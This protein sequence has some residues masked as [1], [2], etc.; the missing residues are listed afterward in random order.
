MVER[1]ALRARSDAA[2]C[3][4]TSDRMRLLL[5]LIACGCSGTIGGT[6]RT[7]TL[8][9]RVVDVETCAS[10]AGCTGIEGM[11]VSLAADPDG[12][13]SAPTSDNGTFVLSGVRTG[14]RQDLVV[15]P[16]EGQAH[17]P[18][19]NPMVITPSD[20]E[21][22]FGVELYALP[23]DP[24]SLLTALRSE[25]I[26]LV[27]GGGYV[28]QAV[29]VTE[30][31]TAADG[32]QVQVY[33]PQGAVRYVHVLPRFVSTEPVLEPPT[34]TMTGVFGSF[35]VPADGPADTVA[36]VASEAG[37]EYDLVVAPFEPG[38]VTYAVQRGVPRP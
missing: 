35:V 30:T 5:L 19:I 18:T 17:A 3:D 7:I 38:F 6:S 15:R 34:A 2:P 10:T 21:D 28:G 12:V 31:V 8:R 36:I 20:S 9:G 1:E 14:Y 27:L 4:R 26:D 29:R 33:P 23:R 13:R 25:G 22:L 24:Q 11:I 16:A 32:V 37:I